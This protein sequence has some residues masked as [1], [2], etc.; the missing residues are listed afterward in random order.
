MLFKQK[1]FSANFASQF[2]LTKDSSPSESDIKFSLGSND[3][4]G[5]VY[6]VF[7]A[8]TIRGIR[9]NNVSG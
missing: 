7:K 1:M 6:M 2:K 3:R 4:F 8:N 9:I 5:Q